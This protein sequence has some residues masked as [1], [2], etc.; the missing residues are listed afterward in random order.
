MTLLHEMHV[1]VMRS[2][3]EAFQSEKLFST[4][5][6]SFTE[7][8]SSV[9]KDLFY[10]F[11][12]PRPISKRIDQVLDVWQLTFTDFDILTPQRTHINNIEGSGTC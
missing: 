3:H 10:H 8:T 1:H 6:H 7:H 5:L 9:K 2:D 12:M 4:L 11:K